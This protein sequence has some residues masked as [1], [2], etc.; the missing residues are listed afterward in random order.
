M[1]KFTAVDAYWLKFNEMAKNG[2]N[3]SE[4]GEILAKVDQRE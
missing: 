3:G 2:Q 4:W 1:M